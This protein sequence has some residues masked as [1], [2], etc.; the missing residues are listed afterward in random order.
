[1]DINA[2]ASL[3]AKANITPY[4]TAQ[5]AEQDDFGKIWNEVS[6]SDKKQAVRPNKKEY[7]FSD[8]KQ[9]VVSNK[10]DR[11]SQ[12]NYDAVLAS[13]NTNYN[14]IKINDYTDNVNETEEL[15]MGVSSDT[16]SA[17]I[18]AD[19]NQQV[20]FGDITKAFADMISTELLSQ[21][22]NKNYPQ[23]TNGQNP[24]EE[25]SQKVSDIMFDAMEDYSGFT[26][27]QMTN[28]NMTVDIMGLDKFVNDDFVGEITDDIISVVFNGD[29]KDKDLTGQIV[30][31]A[32]EDIMLNPGRLI[33]KTDVNVQPAVQNVP[34]NVI[35]QPE[36]TNNTVQN[37]AEQNVQNTAVNNETPAVSTQTAADAPAV[38][39]Q[40]IQTSAPVQEEVRM[41]AMSDGT[42]IPESAIMKSMNMPDEKGI[43]PAGTEY[44]EATPLI[45]KG[46]SPAKAVLMAKVGDEDGLVRPSDFVKARNITFTKHENVFGKSAPSVYMPINGTEESV[47]GV[48][49]Y[50]GS[51]SALGDMNMEM[52][53]FAENN[54]ET[55]DFS[56]GNTSGGEF[57]LNNTNTPDIIQNN[58]P[59][60]Q[61]VQVFRVPEQSQ[62]DAIAQMT[63]RMT[64]NLIQ[65]SNT[66][67]V[68]QMQIQLKPETLGN[69]VIKLESVRGEVNVRIITSNPEVRDMI[70]Q[71]AA[72]MSDSIRAQG[73]NLNNINVST[74]AQQHEN[75]DGSSGNSAYYNDSQGQNQNKEQQENTNYKE[76][77]EAAEDEKIRR[78]IESIRSMGM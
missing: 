2:A 56:G 74:A 77:M 8:R 70:A 47:S 14:Q 59:I 67:E 68:K 38:N 50:K 55:M 63:E 75:F 52:N 25:F 29:V 40:D 18:T 35:Q 1:M 61:P 66:S 10:N 31:S 16:P 42:Y 39:T 45:G 15:V 11:K 9:A 17:E 71:T 41:I 27:T 4:K 73:V 22:I 37:T 46:D 30:K 36:N 54:D 26:K 69:I 57:M 19:A 34:E 7:S 33:S 78:V 76:Y 28:P 23:G 32:V 49:E 3:R 6:F 20:A 24:M 21:Y 58:Q 53:M 13:C 72:N 5:T 60:G 43:Y 12:D 62:A 48:I 64:N 51:D 44:I 65:S